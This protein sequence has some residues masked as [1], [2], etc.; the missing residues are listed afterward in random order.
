MLPLRYAASGRKGGNTGCADVA[1]ERCGGAVPLPAALSSRRGLAHVR[2]TCVCVTVLACCSC[3]P[4]VL[5]GAGRPGVLLRVAVGL[6]VQRVSCRRQGRRRALRQGSLG[7]G[8]QPLLRCKLRRPAGVQQRRLR[9]SCHRCWCSLRGRR[10]AVSSLRRGC[11]FPGLTPLIARPPPAQLERPQTGVCVLWTFPLKATGTTKAHS[12][13]CASSSS[14]QSAS[15]SQAWSK[16]LPARWH[17]CVLCEN[18]IH[19]VKVA[20]GPPIIVVPAAAG[21]WHGS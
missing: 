19:D 2:W 4:N 14:V 5:A 12:R 13:I 15:S 8:S 6:G 16:P 3:W 17:L 7:C 11:A 10:I 21:R 1:A 9:R 20:V 18:A